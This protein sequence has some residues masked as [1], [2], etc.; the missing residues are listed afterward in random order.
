MI[1]QI[2]GEKNCFILWLSGWCLSALQYSWY[3]FEALVKSMAQ[4]LIESCR[5]KVSLSKHMFWTR[6]G[7]GWDHQL[8]HSFCRLQPA[9]ACSQ[10]QN[11]IHVVYTSEVSPTMLNWL[12]LFFRCE[13]TT[14]L[15][16]ALSSPTTGRRLKVSKQAK[17]V[18]KK[19]KQCYGNGWAYPSKSTVRW[20]D[21]ISE[22]KIEYLALTVKGNTSV[23]PQIGSRA[24]S[25][26]FTLQLS[27]NQRFSASFQHSVETLVNLIM[28]HITQKYKD[29]LDAARNA[30]HSL[31]VFI[32]VGTCGQCSLHVLAG[33]IFTDLPCPRSAV[34]T[35]WTEA[36]CSNKST[37]TWAVLR[38][39][40]QR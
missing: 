39:E 27:R 9:R 6:G 24:L 19:K 5:V 17:H 22:G 15:C 40:T 16:V 1:S 8:Y 36:S 38:L 33:G 31:A 11:N 28:P 2:W 29:N 37:T 10:P 3:F 30:N 35:W 7:W 32:K 34:S 12:C 14:S 20:F 23:R 13:V 21:W 4:Y 25:S 18:K 26:I